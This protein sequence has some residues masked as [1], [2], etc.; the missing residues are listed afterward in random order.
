MYDSKSYPWPSLKNHLWVSCSTYW[1]SL[2]WQSKAP[3]MYWDLGMNYWKLGDPLLYWHMHILT[4]SVLSECRKHS[5]I[6]GL[7]IHP[8]PV[9][10]VNDAHRAH[11]VFTFAS[12]LCCILFWG[13]LSEDVRTNQHPEEP[14]SWSRSRLAEWVQALRGEP[15]KRA[16]DWGSRG[17][18]ACRWAQKYWEEAWHNGKKKHDLFSRADA[19]LNLF[20]LTSCVTTG[21]LRRKG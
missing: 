15:G 6:G 14:A 9:N 4:H 7:C 5:F 11:L 18:V 19:S 1:A 13:W 12:L 17:Q 10:S 8:I 16:R 21:R 20:S 3:V 2:K